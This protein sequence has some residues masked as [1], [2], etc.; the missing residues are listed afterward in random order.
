MNST[1]ETILNRHS[2]RVYDDRPISDEDRRLIYRAIAESPSAGNMQTYSVIDIRDREKLDRLAVLCD[3]QPFIA[4][5]RMVLLFVT[6]PLRYYDVYNASHGDK[7]FPTPADLY[8]NFSDALIAAQTAVIA[9][10]SLGI[11]S[12]YIGD[13]I[14]NHEEIKKMFGLPDCVSPVCLLVFGYKKKS[15]MSPARLC[16]EDLITVDSFENDSYGAFL[17]KLRQNNPGATEKDVEESVDRMFSRKM[18]NP[19]FAEMNRSFE[20]VIEEYNEK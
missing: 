11:G 8:L 2:T 3:D 15:G 10:E 14:E 7:L 17:R 4:N 19:F 1:I 13:I 20:L 6:N 16:E 5:G 18:K 9:A 12:C